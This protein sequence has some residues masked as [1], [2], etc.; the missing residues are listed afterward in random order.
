MYV[1]GSD[2]FVGTHGEEPLQRFLCWHDGL[3]WRDSRLGDTCMT[4]ESCSRK[5]E[6]RAKTNRFHTQSPCLCVSGRAVPSPV[7]MWTNAFVESWSHHRESA[8]TT[9]VACLV[10]CS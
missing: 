9:D 10:K 1:T 8:L 7:A 2:G 3:G 4:R 5:R 6:Q